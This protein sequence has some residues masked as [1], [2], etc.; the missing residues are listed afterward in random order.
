[1]PLELHS[2]QGKNVDGNVMHEVCKV[3]GI[4]KTH[5]AP[6]HPQGNSITERENA[7]I[8]AMLSA[9]TNSRQDDWDIYLPAVMMA[10]RSSVHRTMGETPNMMML[11][12]EAR[13]PLD[14]MVGNPPEAEYQELPAT[15][16]AAD[17]AEALEKAHQAV[18]EQVD[19]AYRYQKKQYDRH[20]KANEYQEGQAV[21][22]REF[23]HTPGRS[24]SL[25]R[26][27]SGPWIIKIRYSKAIYKIQRSKGSKSKVIHSD[28]LKPYYGTVTD[29][30]A[31]SLWNPNEIY[32]PL[33]GREGSQ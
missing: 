9:Y 13:L 31:M 33:A 26:P 32:P 27:Y 3:L 30:G 10:Y 2:D 7:V 24:K 8:K 4:R 20:V 12:R 18:S 15:Q 11:G 6:Y 23:P 14:A 22:L 5:T 25:K 17:L 16:Y 28:R 21:W 19:Q 1:M 29:V